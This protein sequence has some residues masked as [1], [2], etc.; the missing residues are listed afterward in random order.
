MTQDDNLTGNISALEDAKLEL[1][2]IEVLVSDL[3]FNTSDPESV[4]EA[5]RQMEE[6]VDLHRFH[7]AEN[8]SVM[9]MVRKF[10]QRHRESYL[11]KTE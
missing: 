1:G 2:Y 11:A 5:I 7:Y 9:Q 10:K 3:Q 6:A 4:K 8:K